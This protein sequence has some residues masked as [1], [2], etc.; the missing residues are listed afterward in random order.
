MR[1]VLIVVLVLMLCTSV[2]AAKPNSGKAVPTSPADDVGFERYW[3]P[4]EPVQFLIAE[5]PGPGALGPQYHGV[6]KLFKG[7]RWIF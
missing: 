5:D 4:N 3:P 2:F 6:W 7:L 1:L